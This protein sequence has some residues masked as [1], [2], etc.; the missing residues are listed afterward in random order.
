MI[1]KII[2]ALACFMAMITRAGA[3]ELGIEMNG[4]LQGMHYQ[5]KDGQTKALPGGS[6]GLSYTFGLSRRWG[7]LTGITGGLYRTQATLPDG[8]VFTYGQVDEAGSAFQYNLKATG[9]KETQ[10]FFAASIPLLLQYHTIGAGTQWYFNGGGKVFFPLNTSIDVSAQQ[11]RL[12]GYYPDLNLEVSNLPQHGFGTLNGWKSSATAKL[13]PAAAL[14]A[15]TGISFGLGSGTRLYTGLY[16]DLGLTDLKDKQ[17]SLPFI[18]YSSSGIKGVQAGSVLNMNDAGHATLLSFGLQ[19]R[20]SF[21]STRARSVAQHKTT[22]TQ[23]TTTVTQPP[24]TVAQ[25]GTPA[26]SYDDS[27]IIQTPVIFGIIGETSI[28]ELQKPHLDQVATIMKQYPSLRISIEGHICNS[29]H[30]M[31]NTKIGIARANAIARYLQGKGIN[32]SR[33]DVSSARE[34]DPVLP[35][36]PAANYQNRRVVITV[37]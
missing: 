12:S 14:S 25:P 11:L 29:L 2:G 26:I 9:Y 13:K 5:L 17:D 28:P 30:E 34:S 31:E 21:G 6:L 4:G 1:G 19:V 20:L 32:R 18:T 7:L 15:A 3:Q 37:Q 8:L 24:T 35:A 27:A 33:M 16:A 10:H 23:Q 36:D 22:L